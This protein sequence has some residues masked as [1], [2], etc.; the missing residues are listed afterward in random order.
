MTARL[1]GTWPDRSE[2]WLAARRGRIGGSD[3]GAVMGWSPYQT[4][5]GLMAEKLGLAEPKPTSKAME[6]GIFLEDGVR[7][8]LCAHEQVE[9]DPERSNGTWVDA[10]DDRIA[11]NADGV[12]TCGKLIEIKV[13]EY[14][15]EEHGWGRAGTKSDKIPLHYKTQVMWGM[16]LFGLDE[17]LVGVLSGQPRFEFARYRLR[18][19][20][21]IYQYLREQAGIFLDELATHQATQKE[22]AA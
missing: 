9:L 16:G 15:D 8:W 17:C 4:R 11:Y 18:F 5:D 3:I 2:Q 22:T 20:P 10:D 6:R 12:T 7:R 21:D 1:L 14:R 19:E 13:P